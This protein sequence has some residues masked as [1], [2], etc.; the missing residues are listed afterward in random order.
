MPKQKKGQQKGQKQAKQK[1]GR[2]SKSQDRPLINFLRPRTVESVK[3]FAEAMSS[4][5]TPKINVGLLSQSDWDAMWNAHYGAIE[6]GASTIPPLNNL[7]Q[8][9]VVQYA[10][11]VNAMAATKSQGKTTKTRP[12]AWNDNKLGKWALGMGLGDIRCH[13]AEDVR[14]LVV[15]ADENLLKVG[16]VE[17]VVGTSDTSAIHLIHASKTGNFGAIIVCGKAVAA[18]GIKGLDNIVGRINDRVV[19]EKLEDGSEMVWLPN[20]LVT[21][22]YLHKGDNSRPMTVTQIRNLPADSTGIKFRAL[23]KPIRLNNVDPKAFFSAIKKY[24]SRA[25]SKDDKGETD[26]DRFGGRK[27]RSGKGSKSPEDRTWGNAGTLCRLSPKVMRCQGLRSLQLGLPIFSCF[28]GDK[29]ED[30][31]LVISFAIGA[32]LPDEWSENT[33]DMRGR[34]AP[35]EAEAEE[36]P[37]PKK[38]AKSKSKSKTKAKGKK[39]AQAVS[40]PA[41]ETVT[42]T[43]E[44]EE[45][46]EAAPADA[47][48]ETVQA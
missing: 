41:P 46:V 21:W 20:Q 23:D 33:W 19:V 2:K 42:D 9:P 12:S 14:K 27:A 16:R 35:E 47:T 4:G 32:R 18:D 24:M 17:Y 7:Y 22:G 11:T 34:L 5:E 1:K 15:N 10:K 31:R 6:E 25:D 44:A 38:K 36:A 48:D 28:E 39:S 3:E 8:P 29:P 30:A 45:T 26:W 43:A 13:H 40:E 37:K